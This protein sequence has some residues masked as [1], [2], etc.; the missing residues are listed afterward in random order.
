MDSWKKLNEE[1]NFEEIPAES[2]VIAEKDITLSA[3]EMMLVERHA[4]S[5]ME[6]EEAQ[7]NEHLLPNSI[8]D[9][10][11]LN[12]W[13]EMVQMRVSGEVSMVTDDE[14]PYVKVNTYFGVIHFYA[15]D[16][17]EAMTTLSLIHI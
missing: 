10:V 17:V 12:E 4:S 13:A 7:P 8:V 5:V 11:T 15:V 2:E 16:Y 9:Y 6:G 1:I 14:A 3:S